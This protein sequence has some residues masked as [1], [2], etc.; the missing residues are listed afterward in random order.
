[1]AYQQLINKTLLYALLRLDWM[2]LLLNYCYSLYVYD[3]S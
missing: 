1:M 3:I 2:L